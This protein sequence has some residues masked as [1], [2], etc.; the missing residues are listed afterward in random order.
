M[1]WVDDS[2]LSYF[3][4]KIKSKLLP[5]GGSIGQALVKASATDYDT[6]WT[7]NPGD[8]TTGTITKVYSNNGFNLEKNAY[9]VKGDIVT[10][11]IQWTAT[12]Q[13]GGNGS[14]VACTIPAQF[15]PADEVRVPVFCA[16]AAWSSFWP[17]YVIIKPNGDITVWSKESVVWFGCATYVRKQS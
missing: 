11:E 7:G 16:N 1:S 12:T 8:Y 14:T 4:G 17:G 5:S 15:A 9:W 10:I 3:W 2:G 13:F 6:A